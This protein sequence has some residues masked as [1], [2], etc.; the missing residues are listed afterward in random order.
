L[1]LFVDK[2]SSPEADTIVVD[3]NQLRVR[4]IVELDRVSSVGA[5]LV[6]TKSFTSSNIPNDKGI[7]VLATKRSEVFLVVREGQALNEDLVKLEALNNLKGVE[8]PDNDVSL[9]AHMSLLA[10]GDVLAGA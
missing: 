9:E 3:G 6:S 7:V 1:N 2:I 10:T 8:V 4:L 5:N